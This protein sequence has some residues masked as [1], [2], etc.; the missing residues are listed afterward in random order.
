MNTLKNFKEGEGTTRFLKVQVL[1]KV[2]RN[3][4]VVSDKT[5]HMLLKTYDGQEKKV[6]EGKGLTIPNPKL[7]DQQIETDRKHHPMRTNAISDYKNDE[8]KIQEL[9]AIGMEQSGEREN[10]NITFKDFE[11]IEEKTIID[12]EILVIVTYLG[13][14]KAGTYGSYRTLR[15]IDLHG[16]TGLLTVN[17]KF[18]HLAEFLK[19]F[20]VKG[21][22]KLELEDES[23]VKFR[24]ATVRQSSLKKTEDYEKFAE[25]KLGHRRQQSIVETISSLNVW[26][27][28]QLHKEK[29]FDIK[30]PSCGDNDEFNYEIDYSVMIMTDNNND[31]CLVAFKKSLDEHI[32]VNGMDEEEISEGLESLLLEAPVVVDYDVSKKDESE[33]YVV[34]IIM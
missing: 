8:A 14:I 9:V 16:E 12:Q 7:S 32:D 20:K 10:V 11:Q 17:G 6:V 13:P 30:C 33:L 28:C 22:K 3:V 4:F 19:T 2:R 24:C 1:K 21:V 29:K 5:D 34:R 27:S 23:D 25:V 31:N 26:F 18:L 15:L